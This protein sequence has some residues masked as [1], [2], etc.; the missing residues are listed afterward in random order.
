MCDRVRYNFLASHSISVYTR[1]I[2]VSMSEIN[3]APLAPAIE[4]FIPLGRSGLLPALHAAQKN[5][6]WIPES[7]AAEVAKNLLDLGIEISKVAK[8]T[9]MTEDEVKLLKD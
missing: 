6:G 7:V 5:Y 8:A 3:L 9:G 4:K 2:G 1:R